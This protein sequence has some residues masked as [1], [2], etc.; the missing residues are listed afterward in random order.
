MF[1]MV[2]K[3]YLAFDFA[4]E[5]KDDY[6]VCSRK[7]GSIAY[8][9]S[10]DPYV[11]FVAVSYEDLI[12]ENF[13]GEEDR[14]IKYITTYPSDQQLTI[15]CDVDAFTKICARWLSAL[16]PN[17]DP[18]VLYTAYKLS[19][20]KMG[21][22]H[23]QVSH[24]PD[25]YTDGFENLEP[26]PKDSFV[27]MLEGVSDYQLKPLDRLN[28]SLEWLVATHLIDPDCFYT[29]EIDKRIRKIIWKLVG[30]EVNELKR[31]LMNGMLDLNYMFPTVQADIHPDT[32]VWDKILA[33]EPTLKFLQDRNCSPHNID[34]I[35][36][37]GLGFFTD[38]WNKYMEYMGNPDRVLQAI[39]ECV[40]ETDY[41]IDDIL[42]I[43]I[44]Q[45]FGTQLFARTEYRFT[46]NP[47]LISYF[48]RLKRKGYTTELRKFALV[49]EETS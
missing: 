41:S 10:T 28:T 49:E 33:S 7:W 20:D 43:D 1:H 15:Y 4:K 19:V 37:Y 13:T 21:Y 17:S 38:L 26:W 29:E 5:A 47:M 30:W 46:M 3:C 44:D 24:F 40:K 11:K 32:D 31:N 8:N 2:N 16:L 42:Q 14:F 39:F 25:R 22:I 27:N 18:D 23:S 36:H 12:A 6:I 48:Y 45:K 9:P 35:Q 34:V